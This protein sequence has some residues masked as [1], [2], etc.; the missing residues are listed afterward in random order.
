[1]VYYG[2]PA[3]WAPSIEDK[4]MAEVKKQNDSVNK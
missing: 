2:L 1:M 4:I 3:F